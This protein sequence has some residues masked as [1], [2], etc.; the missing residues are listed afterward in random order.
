MSTTTGN[1]RWRS[2]SD[3]QTSNGKPVPPEPDGPLDDLWPHLSVEQ[4]QLVASG[5]ITFEDLIERITASANA[6]LCPRCA[7]HP[8]SKQYSRLG[9]CATCARNAMVDA[10]NETLAEIEAMRD[11]QAARQRVHRARISAG[12]P[13][14]RARAGD[15][16]A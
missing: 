1:A 10:A 2:L 14:P 7:M 16:S 3:T 4:Q 5:H 6:E 11:S 13:L 15:E 9:L 12:L 8:I